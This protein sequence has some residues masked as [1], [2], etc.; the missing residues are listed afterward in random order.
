MSAV[1]SS[2][3]FTQSHLGEWTLKLLDPVAA[4]ML[5]ETDVLEGFMAYMP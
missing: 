2:L 1:E 5:E 3:E 4:S